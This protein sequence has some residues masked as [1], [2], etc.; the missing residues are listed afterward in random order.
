MIGLFS[1][2]KPYID[3]EFTS[4][5]KTKTRVIERPGLWM[6]AAELSNLLDDLRSVQQTLGVGDFDYGVLKGEKKTLD[7]IVITIIYDLKT[8]KP[9]AF[10]ALTLMSCLIGGKYETVVHLGLVIVD[11]TYRAKGLSWILYG[12]T[13]FLLFLKNRFAPL[14]ISNVTQV[15]SIIGNVSESFGKVY[16][17]P[18]TGQRRTFEHLV[19]AREILAKHRAVFGVCDE[20]VFDEETFVIKDSYR[21]GSD[22]LKKTFEQTVKHR[23][24][25]FNDF[26]AQHLNYERGDDFLQIGQMDMAT[27]YNYMLHSATKSGF[28]VVF[29]KIVFSFLDSLLV[30]CFQWLSVNRKMGTLR[31]RRND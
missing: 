1:K 2:K 15:P 13:T 3:I 9:F 12:L 29:Y 5:G 4:N 14:Y 22:N 17:N 11:P 6:S 16:P 27:Y 21:G 30:P 8:Q 26:C 10:N 7:S 24:S 25:V 23:N 28:I 19:I 20:A 18:L 31:S